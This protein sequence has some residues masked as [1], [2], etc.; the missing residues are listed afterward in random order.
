MSDEYE[1]CCKS[2]GGGWEKGGTKI[3]M[4]SRNASL[5]ASLPPMSL[6]NLALGMAGPIRWR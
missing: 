4:V 3:I 2:G 5:I 6:V 1:K